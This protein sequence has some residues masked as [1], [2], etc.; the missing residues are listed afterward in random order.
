VA[1]PLIALLR[2][3][4]GAE[5]VPELLSTVRQ[6]STRERET[7]LMFPRGARRRRWR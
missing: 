1:G 5:A 6:Q 7:S 4:L 2:R 3:A